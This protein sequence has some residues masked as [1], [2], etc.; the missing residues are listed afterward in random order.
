M[1]GLQLI[2]V[3]HPN[4]SVFCFVVESPPKRGAHITEIPFPNGSRSLS[5]DAWQLSHGKHSE[6]VCRH[7]RFET[8]EWF[9]EQKQSILFFS[10]HVHCVATETSQKFSSTNLCT[11]TRGNVQK[12]LVK[13]WSGFRSWR[14][15]QLDF[16]FYR[17]PFLLITKNERSSLWLLEL[18]WHQ[19]DY[20]L[21][22]C[23]EAGRFSLLD[24]D[25]QSTNLRLHYSDG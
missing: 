10:N 25:S 14:R 3:F 12:L 9:D 20:K 21:V 17:T 11:I 19:H 13:K 23:S 8:C 18:S 5:L 24:I 2:Y 4:N 7:I 15:F 16:Q 6:W 1:R 22:C